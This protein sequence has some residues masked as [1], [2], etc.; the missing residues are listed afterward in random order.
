MFY[1][2]GY[3]E[4]HFY[5]DICRD[6]KQFCVPFYRREVVSPLELSGA[7]SELSDGYQLVGMAGITSPQIFKLQ[8]GVLVCLGGYDDVK[9]I[10]IK[11]VRD[12]FPVVKF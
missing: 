10:G 8:H 4:C 9:S 1:I 6:L 12:W 3:E 11:N 2:I 7:V 5:K